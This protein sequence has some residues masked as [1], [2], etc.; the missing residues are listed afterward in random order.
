MGISDGR[1][2]LS[3]STGAKIRMVR[4][5][6]AHK[7]LRK[8][9]PSASFVF[10]SR[11]SASYTMCLAVYALSSALGPS[12]QA[13]EE[14]TGQDCTPRCLCIVGCLEKGKDNEIITKYFS[15]A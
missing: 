10:P 3:N 14:Y 5:C 11:G 4:V 1:D 6:G 13:C 7:A 8:S 15:R 2:T 12:G 9:L